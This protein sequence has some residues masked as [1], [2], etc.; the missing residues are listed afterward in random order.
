[1]VCG[2]KARE[3]RGLNQGLVIWLTGAFL[4]LSVS[5]ATDGYAF[6]SALKYTTANKGK[7]EILSFP[8]PLGS[9]PPHVKLVDA[10]TLSLTVPGLLALPTGALDTDRSL[11][12]RS[13]RVDTFPGH[14]WGLQITIT[15]KEPLLNFHDSLGPE[16]PING[17]EYSLEIEKIETPNPGG[18]TRLLEGQVLAGRDGTLLVVSLTGGGI[19]QEEFDKG[20][21]VVRVRWTDASLDESWRS[22]EPGGLVEK[23]VTVGFP[24]GGVEMEVVLHERADGAHFRKNPKAGLFVLEVSPTHGVGRVKE[25]EDMIAARQESVLQK[26]TQPLNRLWPI[27]APASDSIELKGKP[28]DETYFWQHAKEARHDRRFAKARAYLDGLLENFPNTPNREVVD[29][30][31]LDLARELAWK[32]GWLLTELEAAIARHP[33]S[34]NY[35]THRLEQLKLYNEAGRFENAAGMMWD[36][37]LPRDLLDLW[38]AR[39]SAAMGLARAHPAE[40]KFWNDAEQYLLKV[41][42]LSGDRGPLSAE[43]KYLLAS[44]KDHRGDSAGTIETLDNL[45][46]G[47]VADLS[48]DPQKLMGIADLYYK[49]GNHSSAFRHFAAFVEAYPTKNQMVP[50]AILRAAES[51]H[52]MALAAMPKDRSEG[53]KKRSCESMTEV[54]TDAEERLCEARRLFARLQKDHADS[55]AAVWGRILQLAV[56]E[57]L[58]VKGRLSKLDQVIKKIAL[59]D[60]LAEAQLTRAELLGKDGQYKEAI[61]TLN[62]LLTLTSRGVVVRRADQFKKQFLVEGMAVALDEGRPEFAVRLAQTFGGNWRQDPDYADARVHLAEALMRMNIGQQAME[63][64]K[65]MDKPAAVALRQLG[66]A[67]TKGDWSK[68]VTSETSDGRGAPLTKEVARVRLAEANRL[69]DKQEWGAIQGLLER[70]PNGLLNH[71]DQEARLRL[72][73]RAEIGRGRFPQA[74]RNLEA[75]LAGRPVGDGLD[76]YWYAT[77]LQMW[78]GDEKA[79]PEYQRV[80][81]ESVNAEV[82]A[83]ARIRVGDILQRGGDVEAARWNY[84]DAARLAPG[85]SW[86][87]ISQE[88]AS[89]L[90]MNMEA[91]K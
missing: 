84:R 67:L 30:L 37:N 28:V 20:S 40:V 41:L 2:V 8:V 83:L 88:N 25:A 86:S 61:E 50:W 90:K 91:G 12:I 31:K 5:F 16:D 3:R 19:A 11:F 58:D 57:G 10:T 55:D 85:T 51:A 15:L 48:L 65:G 46:S 72:L 74:V 79:L 29:F 49:F 75:L 82:K 9:T 45:S 76:Y 71:V 42:K 62:H 80:A 26:K 38:M 1:M 73:A 33:N 63:T 81:G 44:L 24:T 17:A 68:E 77:V 43:A 59:P 7:R 78:R 69:A 66:A 13:F 6:F 56:E 23:V 60:A 47:Q 21:R 32:P 87:K 36:Y 64:L 54:R 27:Y 39:A 53:V 4:L 22:I 35:P 14:E 34:A 18:P 70:L 89:Q 52:Q